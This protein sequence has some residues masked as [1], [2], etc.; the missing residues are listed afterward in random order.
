MQPYCNFEPF[1]PGVA[2]M[3]STFFSKSTKSGR[4]DTS[5]WTDTPLE[6][7]QKAKMA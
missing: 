2:P 7:A 5:V 4:G 6:K 1:Q 3:Q